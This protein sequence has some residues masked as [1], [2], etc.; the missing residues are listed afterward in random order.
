MLILVLNGLNYGPYKVLIIWKVWS[1]QGPYKDWNHVR[2]S[3]DNTASVDSVVLINK[4]SPYKDHLPDFG[5]YLVLIL[6]I[7]SLI[8]KKC[9]SPAYYVLN[10][11]IESQV[12]QSQQ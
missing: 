5:L 8:A 7:W 10:Q 11:S 6:T 1:L 4:E 9:V 2:T 12:K 3:A